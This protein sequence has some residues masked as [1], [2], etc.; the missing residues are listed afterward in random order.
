MVHLPKRL[1]FLQRLFLRCLHVY[2]MILSPLL[3]NCCRFYPSCADYAQEAIT[4][5]GVIRGVILTV[6]RLCRCHPFCAGGID[7]VPHAEI[8]RRKR[9]LH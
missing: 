1:S 9:P 7:L 3:G 5:H 4:V 6:H 2:K 8:N